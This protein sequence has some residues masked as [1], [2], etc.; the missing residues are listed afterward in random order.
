MTSLF[1]LDNLCR[2]PEDGAYH[3]PSCNA[4]FTRRSNLRRH[5]VI[6]TRNMPFKCDS[7]ESRFSRSDELRY[8]LLSCPEPWQGATTPS[9]PTIPRFS[10]NPVFNVM[11]PLQTDVTPSFLAHNSPPTISPSSASQDADQA[12]ADF[13]SSLSSPASDVIDEFR[14]SYN[15]FG[16]LGN[17]LGPTDKNPSSSNR[18][19]ISRRPSTNRTRLYPRRT[20]IQPYYALNRR[21]KIKDKPIYTRCQVDD[22]LN[23]VS[24][25]FAG[26]MEEVLRRIDANNRNNDKAPDPVKNAV[27][28]VEGP[29]HELRKILSDTLPRLFNGLQNFL[30]ERTKAGAD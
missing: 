1:N 5:F 12:F 24:S 18:S 20:T 7:C 29:N 15:Q 3:C 28:P 13:M 19:P 22:M 16:A 8:H 2:D 11:A 25:C 27:V 17:V 30:D 26:T 10:S 9:F 6:H 4:P 23:A 14:T 21:K